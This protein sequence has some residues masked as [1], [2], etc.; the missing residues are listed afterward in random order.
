MITV[1]VYAK[2]HG[3]L[4][5]A[6][7]HAFERMDVPGV[8]VVASTQPKRADVWICMRTSELRR[9]PALARTVA[10]IHDLYDRRAEAEA[11]AGVGALVLT[12]REQLALLADVG[13]QTA[14]RPVLL[15][16]IGA[17]R[18]FFAAPRRAVEGEFT[19]A[20]LGRPQKHLGEDVKG[21]DLLA[22]I[23][24]RLPRPCQLLLLGESTS[25]IRGPWQRISREM[26]PHGRYPETLS[27]VDAVVV[28]SKTEAGPLSLFEAL[29]VGVPV[30]STRVGWAPDLLRDGLNGFLRSDAGGF[31]EALEQIRA[32][33]AGWRAKASGIRA[34]L[35]VTQ[36]SWM[37]E[38]LRLAVTLVDA[39]E[40]AA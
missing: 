5:D 14:D 33:R 23:A 15:R 25:L 32:D 27:G 1:N 29:A 7:L 26:L 3:W 37:E 12:H 9:S 40:G 8:R 22:E 30:V 28:A 10:M 24:W 20:W 13:V 39:E 17:K 2:S 19:V 34:T 35:S 11:L 21:I 36:E 4:F 6:F 38:V 31:V 16:P 18:A